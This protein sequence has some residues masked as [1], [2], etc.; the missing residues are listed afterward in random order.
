M[1]RLVLIALLAVAGCG[2]ATDR[3]AQSA[4]SEATRSVLLIT[5]DTLRADRV[6]TYGL[7]PPRGR[8]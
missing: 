6:G 8:R 3:A 2:K 4:P 5:I 7:T 1:M